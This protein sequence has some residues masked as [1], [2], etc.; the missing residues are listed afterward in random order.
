[1]SYFVWT[2]KKHVTRAAAAKIDAAVKLI[3]PSME[4]VRHYAAGNDTHGW[5]ER[6]N[7]GTNDYNHV[8]A[9]SAKCIEIAEKA[10]A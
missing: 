3:D 5:L 6:P 9:R 10:L 4:F 2:T 8:R 1:M 7:D